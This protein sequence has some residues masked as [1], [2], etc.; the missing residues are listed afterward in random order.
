MRDGYAPVASGRRAVAPVACLLARPG[1]SSQ[2][3]EA[4]PT[5]GDGVCGGEKVGALGQRCH[6]DTN[7][8]P[9]SRHVRGLRLAPRDYLCTVPVG[10][11][12]IWSATTRL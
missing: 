3:D 6:F 5:F 9:R 8:M 2:T 12:S 7:F 4:A 10:P 1:L 11:P